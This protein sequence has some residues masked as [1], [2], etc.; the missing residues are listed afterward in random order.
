[1]ERQKN[2]PDGDRGSA[3]NPFKGS[4]SGFSGSEIRIFGRSKI[5]LNSEP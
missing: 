5:S 4:G 3:V 1:M 2:R